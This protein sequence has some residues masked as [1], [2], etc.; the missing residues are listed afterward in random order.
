M[1]G[2]NLCCGIKLLPDFVNVDKV[3]IARKF[4]DKVGDNEFVCYDLNEKPWPWGD[5]WCD[6][7]IMRDGIEHLAGGTFVEIMEE[8]WRML[9]PNGEFH[10]QVPNAANYNAFT[11]PTHQMFFT[12]RSF[13]YFDPSTVIGGLLPH[14]SA[15]KFKILKIEMPDAG[16]LQFHLRKIP[17]N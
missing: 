4:P 3:D 7:V 12:D 16:T 5:G 1:T 8:V 15:C 2:L 10:C 11:D 9:K 17:C 6:H 14:Y 13:D